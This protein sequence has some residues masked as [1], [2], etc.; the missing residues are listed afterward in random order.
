MIH[1]TFQ[2]TAI[3]VERSRDGSPV[4]VW[5][6][7]QNHTPQTPLQGTEPNPR[8][9]ALG[10]PK[11]SELPTP[12]IDSYSF[13]RLRN[14]QTPH[15]MTKG[16]FDSRRGEEHT[17]QICRFRSAAVR[18]QVVRLSVQNS[19]GRR[20]EPPYG[21]ITVLRAFPNSSHR[22]PLLPASRSFPNH[23]NWP[24]PLRRVV[25]ISPGSFCGPADG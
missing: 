3:R 7:E 18:G 8:P 24:C 19:C 21:S 15:R 2:A 5:I 16:L 13:I 10:Q 17:V 6:R 4:Q 25:P 12:T 14:V 20:A 23:F 11:Q 9:V 22:R 1:A